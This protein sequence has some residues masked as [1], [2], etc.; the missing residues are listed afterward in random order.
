MK[1][2]TGKHVASGQKHE[3]KPHAVSVDRTANIGVQQVRT[4]PAAPMFK[5]QGYK[6]PISGQSNHKSGSQGKH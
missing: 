4:R 1:Q 5:T 2:G 3:P 6:A